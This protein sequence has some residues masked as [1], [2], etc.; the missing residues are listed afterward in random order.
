MPKIT[1]H[2]GP[3]NASVPV[4]PEPGE[5]VTSG[6][7]TPEEHT[8]VVNPVEE[9][10]KAGE[11]VS[12]GYEDLTKIELQQELD[13]RRLTKAGN[14]DELIERLREDDAAKQE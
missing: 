8:E 14:K 10:E 7:V 1:L 12:D 11:P 4:E 9:P 5:E 13:K 6:R 3:S 2:G